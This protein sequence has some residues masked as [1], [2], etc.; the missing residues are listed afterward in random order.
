MKTMFLLTKS[1]LLLIFVCGFASYS[2]SPAPSGLSIMWGRGGFQYII[3]ENKQFFKLDTDGNAI[4]SSGTLFD[5]KS[6]K[7]LF[8][9]LESLKFDKCFSNNQDGDYYVIKVSSTAGEH[10]VAWVVPDDLGK[11]YNY[12]IPDFYAEL[13][14]F[15][16]N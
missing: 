3:Y 8:S 9:H 2:F 6:V 14:S 5:K 7:D 13:M 1:L 16:R 15:V 10:Q 12:R 11:K 4:E